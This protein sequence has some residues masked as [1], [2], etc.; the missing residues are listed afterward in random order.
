MVQIFSAGRQLQAGRFT[1]HE[2]NCSIS[3]K[4]S[5]CENCNVKRPACCL[6]K[7]SGPS[8]YLH[9]TVTGKCWNCPAN[10]AIDS[11]MDGQMHWTSWNFELDCAYANEQQ[12]VRLANGLGQ[13]SSAIFKNKNVFSRENCAPCPTGLVC[14]QS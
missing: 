6:L 8:T 14:R 4:F 12:K 3:T 11:N 9:A 7:K 5:K 13:K 2:K 10:S 1:I